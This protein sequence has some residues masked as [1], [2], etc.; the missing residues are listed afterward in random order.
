MLENIRFFAEL[1]GLKA[2]EWRPRCMQILDFVGLAGFKD[3]LA[4]QLSG[5]MKQKLGLASALVAKPR[6]LLLDEPTTG[7]DPVTRQDFWQ[8]I[9]HL[10]ANPPDAGG[11]C[12]VISTPYMDEAARCHRL[13]FMRHG[14]IVAEGTAGQLRL[15]L[16]ERILELHGAPLPLLQRIAAQDP[17]VEDVRLFGD[18]LHLRLAA[19]QRQAV[20]ERLQTAIP[21]GGGQL[22]DARPIPPSSKM[23][24]SPWQTARPDVNPPDILVENLTRRFGDFVAVDHVSFAVQPGEIM[25]YLGPNGSGKT[26]TIRMLLGLLQAQR[27]PRQRLRLRY[28]RPIRRNPERAAATCRRNSPSTTT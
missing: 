19:G 21:Q 18:R 28:C 25:G 10:V 13:G 16:N 3:R 24:S 15:T 17:G 6:V 11:V 2:S 22:S 4:G 27:G 8:L 5:G 14:K 20:I 26:T 7:V 9:I 1:R 12:V 23:S